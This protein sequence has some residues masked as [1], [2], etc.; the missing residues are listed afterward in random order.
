MFIKIYCKKGKYL[1]QR[2][3]LTFTLALSWTHINICTDL[4]NRI[5]IYIYIFRDIPCQ[6]SSN[7]N[8]FL[9]T[10]RVFTQDWLNS[11]W[12]ACL[13]TRLTELLLNHRCLLCLA[14]YIT[15]VSSL[16]IA[17]VWECFC[18]ISINVNS[19]FIVYIVYVRP[20][21]VVVAC[22]FVC[23]LFLYCTLFLLVYFFVRYI[24]KLT[25]LR[26]VPG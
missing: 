24:F 26:T 11:L 25:L 15:N 3:T 1:F 7:H 9:F 12:T 8:Y 17:I 22:L 21:T 2:W 14:F 4:V 13:Y 6:R 10:Q 20:C 5:F 19:L 16:M 23:P 18:E